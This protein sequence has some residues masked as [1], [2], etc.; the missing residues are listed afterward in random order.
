MKQRNRFIITIIGAGK[1]GSVLGRVLVERGHRVICV[2]SRTARS[3][4]EAGRFLRCR[5]TS[6]V[7]PAIPPETNLILITTPHDAVRTVAHDLAL[8]DGLPFRRIAVCHASGMLSA[9]VLSPLAD[10]GATVFSF[11]PLQTFP[12]DF[13]P[14]KILPTVSGIAYGVDGPPRGLRTA[15]RLARE[16]GGTVI[17]IRPELRELY[18]AACV[19]A[20]NHLTTMLAVV[21]RMFAAVA[22]DRKRFYPVFRPILEATLRNSGLTSPAEALSGPIARGGTAT[23]ARHLDV[24]ARE[25]P[26]ILPYFAAVSLETVRLARVKG[27]ITAAQA[28]ELSA[29]LRNSL[30]TNSRTEKTP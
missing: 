1:V 17:E 3:A 18:H 30:T 25:V 29:L 14:A 4:R 11:H 20:S 27:S 7:L 21:E 6:T 13:T 2:V 8:V 12:R 9:A 24:I 16:L 22:G 19:V 26:E 23:V 15:R 10:L 5:R 28:E